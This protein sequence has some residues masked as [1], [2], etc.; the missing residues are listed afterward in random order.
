MSMSPRASNDPVALD[1]ALVWRDD[2]LAFRHVADR[3]TVAAGE[4]P[5][6]LGP[7]PVEGFAFA[8]LDAGVAT[9]VIPADAIATVRRADASY[10]IVSGPAEVRLLRG[11]TLDLPIGALVLRASAV[12][13]VSL[14]LDAPRGPRARGALFHI[15]LAAA[16]HLAVL[17]LSL[18][19]AMASM[20]EDD[21][22][23][24]IETAHD[25]LIN[26]ENQ[27]R[28]RDQ[29]LFS[30]G[31]N[32]D[33]QGSSTPR[34]GDGRAGGG[35]KAAGTEGK[36]GDRDSTSAK[37]GRYAV[38]ERVKNDLAPSLAREEALRSAAK[39]GM[40]GLLGQGPAVPVAA[41]WSADLEAHGN[42][43]IAA[44]G[45]MWATEMGS[46]RGD[47]GLGLSDIGEGGGGRGEGIGLGTI[48]TLGHLAGHDGFGTGGHGTHP[49]GSSGGWGSSARLW[50]SH[51]SKWPTYRGDYTMVNGRLPPDAIRRIIRQNFGRFRLC[52][53]TGLRANPT[54]EGR[55]TVRFVIGRDGSVSSVADG[56]SDLGD[57]AV[58]SCVVRAFYGLSF[59]QPEG[60][61]VT[62]TY[63]LV[64][65]P[66]P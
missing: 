18:H 40:I 42:D 14:T 62:V 26:A 5:G 56:G 28:A 4:G 17:G 16:A 22:L 32:G 37:R 43:A 34:S 31:G 19:A 21:E 9:A 47:F 8:R 3:G 12:A 29:P 6:A 13:P 30:I 66:D 35:T 63:P 57:P 49:G 24:Q 48:G 45:A 36:M 33:T 27:D 38:P 1:A 15:G 50:A 55:V 51:W 60:G 64:F 46:Y 58:V 39:F 65:T 2:V 41:A 53:E 10:E 54:L 11:D 59:P 23:S 7:I 20:P 44:R 52:Y 25:L 61:I